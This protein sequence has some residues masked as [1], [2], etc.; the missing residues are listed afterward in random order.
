MSEVISMDE[1]GVEQIRLTVNEFRGV[2]Y[3]HLRN[4]YLDFD[5]SWQPTPKGIAI[6]ITIQNIS[7]IFNALTK[8]LAQSDVLHIILEN[9][10]DITRELIYGELSR[11]LE[12]ISES[13]V[14]SG[15][16]LPF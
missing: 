12:N 2:Q 6:P 11:K 8:M 9:S 1:N 5:E 15:D 10:N 13:S 14:L 3:L 7:N 4:Y 16:S